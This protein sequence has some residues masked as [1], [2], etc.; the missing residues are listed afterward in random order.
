MPEDPLHQ[1]HDKLFKTTFGDPANAA[2]F[3]REQLPP[4]ISAAIRWD[5]LRRVQDKKVILDTNRAVIGLP[6]TGDI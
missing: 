4:G 2:A 5:E 3:L 1:P 6:R